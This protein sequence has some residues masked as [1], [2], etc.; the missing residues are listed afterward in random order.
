LY[1]SSYGDTPAP[2]FF[3]W[4]EI[5]HQCFCCGGE[6]TLVYDPTY[7]AYIAN[8]AVTAAPTTFNTTGSRRRLMEADMLAAKA[9]EE[10]DVVALNN[11][12]C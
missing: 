5:T 6:C 8:R 11:G 12:E 10:A 7:T 2:F 4:R 9:R 3:N 1:C